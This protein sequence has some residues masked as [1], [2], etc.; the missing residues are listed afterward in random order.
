MIS[1]NDTVEDIVDD[2]VDTVVDKAIEEGTE[3]LNRGADFAVDAISDAIDEIT[4]P[5]EEKKFYVFDGIQYPI[6]YQDAATFRATFKSRNWLKKL[7]NRT[8][9]AKTKDGVIYI[10]RDALLWNYDKLM[11]HEIGHILGLKHSPW[12]KFTIMHPLGLF[13]WFNSW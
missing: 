1:S 2:V 4:H 6:V 3:F 12:W 10:R 13:R 7:Y 11:M 8:V 5:R 9:R